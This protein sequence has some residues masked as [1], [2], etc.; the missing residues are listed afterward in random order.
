MFII[1]SLYNI[2]NKVWCY[3]LVNVLIFY[4]TFTSTWTIPHNVFGFQ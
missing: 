1:Q 2:E 3:T 4:Y